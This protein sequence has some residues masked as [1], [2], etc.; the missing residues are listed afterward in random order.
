MTMGENMSIE[1]RTVVRPVE[2]R[3]A[4]NGRSI[5]GYAAVF[6]SETDIGGYFR[7]KIAPGAFAEAIKADVRA[8]I[9]HDSGRVIGRSTAGT[10]RMTEDENGLAVEIDLPDTTDG[11]DLATLIERGDISGMSF[12]FMVT[13]QSWDE[14]GDT[15]LRTIEAVDLFEVSVVAFPAYDDTSI[16]MRSLESSRKDKGLNNHLG[17]MRR[18]SQR[19]ARMEQQFRKI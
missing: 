3:A 8:L 5:G 16:A 6:N 13:K 18:I 10:L 4:K 15:P 2:I 11:R 7:E 17:A 14:T 19:K 1:K 9:D 12:G